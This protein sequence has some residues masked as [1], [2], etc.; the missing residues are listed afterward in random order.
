[1]YP[2]TISDQQWQ[3]LATLLPPPASGTHRGGRPEKHCR[4]R[5]LDAVFYLVRAGLAWRQLPVEFP[6][7]PTVYGRFAQW[8]DD[9]TWQRIH[10]ALRDRVRVG[11]D[12]RPTPSAAIIDSQSVRAG[13][14]VS[15]KTRGF[16]GA[17]KV[18]GRYLEL[19]R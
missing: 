13:T 2:S 12:R 4:R 14:T 8:R 9:G 15:R 10:D 7:W 11:Q 5:I 18:N 16:D 3:V 1:V 6:P 19:A 17:K